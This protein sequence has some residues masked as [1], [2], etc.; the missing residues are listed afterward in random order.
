MSKKFIANDGKF[1]VKL[2]FNSNRPKIFNNRNRGSSALLHLE[3]SLNRDLKMVYNCFIKKYRDLN[4][5]SIVNSN[6]CALN[7]VLLIKNTIWF[8]GSK[9]LLKSDFYLYHTQC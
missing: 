4:H 1:M 7:F 2:P 5:M 9:F 6:P 8:N 3:R